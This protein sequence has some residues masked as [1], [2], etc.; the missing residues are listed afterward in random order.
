MMCIQNGVKGVN[1]EVKGI[2]NA[3]EAARSIKGWRQGSTN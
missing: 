2:E 1:A 3:I